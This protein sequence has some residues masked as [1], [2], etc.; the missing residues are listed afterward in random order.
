VTLNY[1][2]SSADNTGTFEVS[3]GNQRLTGRVRPTASQTTF[4]TLDAGEVTLDA[5]EL[6]V[7][8]RAKEIAGGELMRLRRIELTP[9]GPQ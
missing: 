4:V 1:A 3:F 9:A 2:T 8:I 6:T 5:G 7:G